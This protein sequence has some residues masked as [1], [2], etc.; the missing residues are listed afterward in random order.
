VQTT[1]TQLEKFLPPHSPPGG[2]A[3]DSTSTVLWAL[4]QLDLWPPALTS[5]LSLALSATVQGRPPAELSQAEVA[6]ISTAAWALSKFVFSVTSST[7]S[8][9]QA[10]LPYVAPFDNRSPL[11]HNIDGA[12]VYIRNSASDAS[13]ASGSFWKWSQEQ[14]RTEEPPSAARAA[15]L[16]VDDAVLAVTNAEQ[17]SVR[18]GDAVHVL[19]AVTR[20]H[21]VISPAVVRWVTGPPFVDAIA[22][23][24]ATDDGTF[25]SKIVRG[26]APAWRG[27]SV[28]FEAAVVRFVVQHAANLSLATLRSITVALCARKLDASQARALSQAI[29]RELSVRFVL[30]LF[31][32]EGA[33]WHDQVDSKVSFVAADMCCMPLMQHSL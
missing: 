31:A 23:A 25:V 27:V 2:P 6:L 19:I 29:L 20:V 22:R 14:A 3:L 17:A 13:G 10:P 32:L 9:P 8:E 12:A 28:E 11:S 5:G 1:L 24:H 7:T 26:L 18:L 33:V 15:I 4:A 21:G 16:A 30:L